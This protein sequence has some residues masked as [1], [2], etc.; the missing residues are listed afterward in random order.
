MSKEVIYHTAPTTYAATTTVVEVG[1]ETVEQSD[2]G[3][4]YIFGK[5]EEETK[6]DDEQQVL[7]VKSEKL[8]QDLLDFIQGHTNSSGSN[9]IQDKT[10]VPIQKYKEETHVVQSM[11][12]KGFIEKIK[13]DHQDKTSVPI[14]KG[15]ETHVVQSKEKKGIIEKIKDKLHDS[16]IEKIKEKLP[17]HH[18]KTEEVHG[19][20]PPTPAVV[21]HAH[22]G[23]HKEKKGIFEKIKDKIPG[24]H[25]K[26]EEEKKGK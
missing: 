2:R 9:V 1:H 21:A 17:G 12:K 18:K 25:P 19:A 20:H 11:E 5:K 10:S 7:K 22:E 8:K 24:H 15:E 6:F 14:Q 16:P 3:M 4:F 23:E 13:S 26:S